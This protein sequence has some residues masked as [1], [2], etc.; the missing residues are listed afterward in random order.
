MQTDK[1]RV[2]IGEDRDDPGAWWTVNRVLN[3]YGG[4][5]Y[6]LATIG[7]SFTPYV[8]LVA[9]DSWEDAWS[10]MLDHDEILHQIGVDVDELDDE[11]RAAL[12]RGETVSGVEYNE[13]GVLVWTEWLDMRAEPIF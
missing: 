3:E 5:H 11:G 10:N 4:Q 1:I 8:I 7:G 2:L 6:Y 12:E 9:G 13:S